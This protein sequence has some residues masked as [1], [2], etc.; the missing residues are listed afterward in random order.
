MENSHGTQVVVVGIYV[1]DRADKLIIGS[2]SEGQKL[3]SETAKLWNTLL[4]IFKTRQHSIEINW[5]PTTSCNSCN[6]D[7]GKH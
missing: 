1:G 2:L 6:Y 4:L 5:N 7:C 3:I